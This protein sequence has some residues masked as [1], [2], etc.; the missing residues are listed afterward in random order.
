MREDFLHYIWK[1]KAFD[2]SNLKTTNNEAV[3]IKQLGQHNHNAGPD[4][5][6]A[7]VCT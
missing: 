4:F 7:Q 2:T 5:F 1:Q 3:T 6:N